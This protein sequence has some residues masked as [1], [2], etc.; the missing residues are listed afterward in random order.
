MV[1]PHGS[2]EPS[3]EGAG[4]WITRRRLNVRQFRALR[5]YA[6]SLRFLIGGVRPDSR[7]VR[8]RFR[9]I[10]S[11]AGET[12]TENI[13]K[14]WARRFKS[15]RANPDPEHVRL[16]VW[17]DG[18]NQAARFPW[19]RWI[20]GMARFLGKIGGRLIVTTNTWHHAEIRF[21]VTSATERVVVEEWS[22]S[23]LKDIL[24][25]RGI[26]SDVLAAEVF[27][28]LRNPRILGI[29]VELLDAKE[30]E[31]IDELTVERLLFEHIRR[32]DRDA[33]NGLTARE[34]AKE[35]RKHAE[36]MLQRLTKQERNDLTIFDL[37]KNLSAVSKSRFFEPVAGDGD[38]YAIRKEG[39]P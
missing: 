5:A 30:I 27:D 21:A 39:L 29:A 11:H 9:R 10:S 35:L 24:D 12:L 23:E 7:K 13:R 28:F 16:V 32:H 22:E 8:D 6:G 19:P 26:K 33:M 2:H 18:L 4:R 3:R 20:D 34:F 1:S 15:W 14:R 31:R 25:A 36:E 37:D 17:V 38:L